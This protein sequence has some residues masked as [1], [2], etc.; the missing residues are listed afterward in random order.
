MP[1]NL[2]LFNM[3]KEQ[4]T[5]GLHL[6]RCEPLHYAKVQRLCTFSHALVEGEVL[7]LVNIHGSHLDVMFTGMSAVIYSHKLNSDLPEEPCL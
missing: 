7:F 1:V 6:H 2:N 5:R 3:T 4:I